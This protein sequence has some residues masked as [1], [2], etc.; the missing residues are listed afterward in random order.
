MNKMAAITLLYVSAFLSFLPIIV[1]F[2]NLIFGFVLFGN[3]FII[4]NRTFRKTILE[5]VNIVMLISSAIFI[6][7]IVVASE[8]LGNYL[9]LPWKYF[10]PLGV[11][12][13]INA[14]A[15]LK[16]NKTLGEKVEQVDPY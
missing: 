2:N 3:M 12:A 11:L 7:Y 10:Y 4:V 1:I 6:A 14:S 5:R 13:L 15:M 8:V 16:L 9:A